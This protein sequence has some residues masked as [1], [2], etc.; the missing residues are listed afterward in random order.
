MA[1]IPHLGLWLATE[2][3][4]ELGRRM[5]LDGKALAGVGSSSAADIDAKM[6]HQRRTK[7]LAA[8]ITP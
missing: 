2:E 7:D 4:G 6:R 8:M 1:P 3:H 5:H